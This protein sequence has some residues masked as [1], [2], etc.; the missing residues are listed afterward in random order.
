MQD[1]IG[2]WYS[3]GGTHEELI[4]HRRRIRQQQNQGGGYMQPEELYAQPQ[5]A[6][7][8]PGQGNFGVS[9]ATLEKQY[10]DSI[11]NRRLRGEN[12]RNPLEGGKGP[13]VN[14]WTGKK[15]L[16]TGHYEAFASR[17]GEAF[18]PIPDQDK[19][20]AWRE[21]NILSRAGTPR[22]KDYAQNVPKMFFGTV[23]EG[24]DA[25]LRRN[26][27]TPLTTDRDRSEYTTM[28]SEW[29]EKAANLLESRME[30]MTPDQI[31]NTAQELIRMGG[32]QIQDFAVS[33]VKRRLGKTQKGREALAAMED[34]YNQSIHD[35]GNPLFSGLPETEQGAIRSQIAHYEAGVLPAG[36]T[37]QSMGEE[38]GVMIGADT[39]KEDLQKRADALKQVYG[40]GQA[41]P[42]VA[43]PTVQGTVTGPRG[44]LRMLSDGTIL[45]EGESMPEPKTGAERFAA[46]VQGTMQSGNGEKINLMSDGTEQLDREWLE[47][48][49]EEAQRAAV[50]SFLESHKRAG[51]SGLS[52]EYKKEMQQNLEKTG[53]GDRLRYIARDSLS[54][55]YAAGFTDKTEVSQEAQSDP[56][57]SEFMETRKATPPNVSDIFKPWEGT[58]ITN[59]IAQWIA[60]DVRKTGQNV[61]DAVEGVKWLSSKAKQMIVDSRESSREQE[62]EEWKKKR[63]NK[64]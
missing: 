38:Q 41:A 53:D 51:E 20:N 29:R 47:S 8:V 52:N 63:G 58:R 30:N 3:N 48:Q 42:G 22:D 14:P 23:G 56:L 6:F 28:R 13:Q 43:A 39:M 24:Q 35:T 1:T 10:T 36:E 40:I 46:T 37:I 5:G 59:D 11:R 32:A 12:V 57:F 7:A 34:K 61:K 16:S 62:F 21:G 44:E 50:K 25:A 31:E 64:E 33:E 55:K 49:P 26:L 19:I 15:F 60:N 17:V 45:G 27:N 4:A 2:S 54:E 9:P 18:Q